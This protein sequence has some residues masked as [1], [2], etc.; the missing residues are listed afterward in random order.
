MKKLRTVEFYKRAD[1]T[2]PVS[3]WL[4]TLDDAR[5]Q[6]V[7]ICIK[8]F[9]EYPSLVVPSDIIEKVN[10]H[11][12]EIRAHHG[13][14]QF[15]LYCF[16][17]EALIVAAVGVQKKWKKAR[18]SDLDLAEDR[19]KDHFQRKKPVTKQQTL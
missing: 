12:W 13:K 5:A 8:F 4:E 1:G 17:D 14:E 18:K 6:S 19:R 7:A 15:R 3:E 10:P 2:K 9:E 16:R 11:V